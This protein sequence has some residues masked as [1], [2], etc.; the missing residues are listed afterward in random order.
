MRRSRWTHNKPCEVLSLQSLV[1]S[2]HQGIHCSSSPHSPRYSMDSHETFQV[3]SPL[4]SDGNLCRP[5]AAS[6]VP[7]SVPAETWQPACSRCRPIIPCYEKHWRS[8]YRNH[9]LQNLQKSTA[10]SGNLLWIVGAR[11]QVSWAHHR[12]VCTKLCVDLFTITLGGD[13]QVIFWYWDTKSTQLHGFNL[14]LQM[15]FVQAKWY[16][17]QSCWNDF[18]SGHDCQRL[19]KVHPGCKNF[20]CCTTFNTSWTMTI[21]KHLPI[22]MAP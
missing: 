19:L 20:T 3:T 5:C 1:D 10:F 11:S 2:C 6:C 14:L 13:S 18:L 16:Q 17:T 4:R 12:I 22:P 21:T 9:K 8:W 15:Q 7:R